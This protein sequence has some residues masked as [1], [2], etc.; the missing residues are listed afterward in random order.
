MKFKTLINDKIH[1]MERF[2]VDGLTD[3]LYIIHTDQGVGLYNV[4]RGLPEVIG[5]YTKIEKLNSFICK[6]SHPTGKFDLYNLTNGVFVMKE[7]DSIEH[8]KDS[9][10]T[11]LKKDGLVY[12]YEGWSNIKQFRSFNN[13]I[14]VEGLTATHT[15]KEDVY[16]IKDFEHLGDVVFARSAF[17]GL[18]IRAENGDAYVWLNNEMHQVDRLFYINPSSP[19]LTWQGKIVKEMY[20]NID[21][22]PYIDNEDNLIY[23]DQVIQEAVK[24]ILTTINTVLV[25]QNQD[26]AL[27]ICSKEGK[28]YPKVYPKLHDT[29][30]D[31][32]VIR[33]ME[34]NTKVGMQSKDGERY[35][36]DVWDTVTQ[37]VIQ[38]LIIQREL[39]WD[40]EPLPVD[41][42]FYSGFYRVV[43]D[44]DVIYK[45]K[46]ELKLEW[47]AEG[48]PQFIKIIEVGQDN[49]EY[50]IGLITED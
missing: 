29:D 47:E 13:P 1:K 27:Q 41:I 14:T 17:T 25:V 21:K 46:N 37:E 36:L 28:V 42:I 34:E 18:G 30:T 50:V 20:P 38:G 16:R 35:R 6:L 10:T 7:V 8:I 19:Y 12:K 32:I 9:K 39:F 49:K 24:S 15:D 31:Y 44:E 23:Q 26:G 22:K 5:I 2:E 11:E 48:G 3:Q 43:Q 4:T 40:E 45:S 33:A